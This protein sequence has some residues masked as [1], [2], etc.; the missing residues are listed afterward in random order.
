MNMETEAL[1]DLIREQLT[2]KNAPPEV[3]LVASWALQFEVY[4]DGQ[5]KIAQVNK[6]TPQPKT[7]ILTRTGRAVI[8]NG[9]RYH[10]ITAAAAA[11]GMH[12]YWIRRHATNK[13]RG[14]AWA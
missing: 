11:T 9:T 8:L 3:E 1:L 2:A 4:S 5:V 6:A 10:S 13:H 7:E 12:R 14:W